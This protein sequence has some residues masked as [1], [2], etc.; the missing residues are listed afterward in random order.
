[1]MVQAGVEPHGGEFWVRPEQVDT[2]DDELQA[3][4]AKDIPER[5]EAIFTALRIACIT[6]MQRAP[7]GRC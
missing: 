2:S 7:A 5:R 6:L 1:M 3:L 4:A